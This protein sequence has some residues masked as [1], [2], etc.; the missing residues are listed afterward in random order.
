M[1]GLYLEEIE[2]GRVVELGSHHFTTRGD[3]RLRQEI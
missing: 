3:H 2:V 1:I